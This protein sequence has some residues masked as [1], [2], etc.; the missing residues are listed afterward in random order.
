MIHA[1]I[2]TA[3]PH[4][5]ALKRSVVQVSV[6]TIRICLIFALKITKNDW[7]CL[8][9]FDISLI[10]K[11]EAPCRKQSKNRSPGAYVRINTVTLIK[12]T[13]IHCLFFVDVP[14]VVGLRQ[15]D[16]AEAIGTGSGRLHD[17]GR[18]GQGGG[19]ARRLRQRHS[20]PARRRQLHL[21]RTRNPR[22]LV[23]GQRSS[24]TYLS[25]LLIYYTLKVL[26]NGLD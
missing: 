16:V 26:Y 3:F 15:H 4:S 8:K 21:R 13:S 24:C 22:N 14:I 2:K 6:E 9:F 23:C 18:V 17:A 1:L 20:R 7:F 12:I 5:V 25:A 19:R 10:E 11:I